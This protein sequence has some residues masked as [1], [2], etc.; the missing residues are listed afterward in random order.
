MFYFSFSESKTIYEVNISKIKRFSYVKD[1]N[2]SCVL[3]E[4]LQLRLI[5]SFCNIYKVR[6]CN[7]L[8]TT[9]R[10]SLLLVR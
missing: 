2:Y 9:E 7:Q 1:S 4:V 6:K 3:L 10:N 8:Y 5:S